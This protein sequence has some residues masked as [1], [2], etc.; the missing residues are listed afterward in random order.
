MAMIGST[1]SFALV[2]TDLAKMRGRMKHIAHGL[3]VAFPQASVRHGIDFSEYDSRQVME[4]FV[5]LTLDSGEYLCCSIDIEPSSQGFRIDASLRRNTGDGESCTW[6]VDYDV[7]KMD[8]LVSQLGSIL[9]ATES[10]GTHT[11]QCS[12]R[13]PHASATGRV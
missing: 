8:E 10:Y 11:T 12:V 13:D 7:V 9:A 6:Q 4:I 5:E 1:E 2:L 3:R